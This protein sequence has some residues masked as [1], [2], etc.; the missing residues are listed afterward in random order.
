MNDLRETFERPT[1]GGVFPPFGWRVR[2]SAAAILAIGLLCGACGGKP[3]QP[4]TASTPATV[5][6]PPLPTNAEAATIIEGSSDFGE[7]EFTNAA[8]TVPLKTSQMNDPQRENAELL[9]KAGWL[10]L[11]GGEV[12][13]TKGKGDPRFLVRPNGFL[14]VVPIAKKKMGS[15]TAVRRSSDG[16]TAD[17]T[18]NW[19][20]TEVGAAF[21][22]GSVHAMF[23]APHRATATLIRS[24][25]SWTILRIRSAE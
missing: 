13:L 6:A 21:T 11:H 9:A 20:P 19:V 16:C 5:K 7:F 23:D 22:S 17:F 14:D 10:S 24:G 3:A 8:V 4:A 25:G 15:V 2:A 1:S 18:W 12:V